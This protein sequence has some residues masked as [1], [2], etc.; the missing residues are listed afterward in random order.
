[1]AIM[2]S[3]KC[4]QGC[5]EI[6]YLIHGWWECKVMQPLLKNLVFAQKIKLSC[7]L[8]QQFPS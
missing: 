6:R 3:S 7:N 1:M 2:S 4:W 8:A 5:G